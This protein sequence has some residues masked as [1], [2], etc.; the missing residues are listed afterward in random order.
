[1]KKFLYL[2]S[3]AVI[4][5][6]SC[7][8]DLGFKTQETPQVEGKYTI[9]ANYAEMANGE[10]GTRTSLNSAGQYQWDEG[11]A[12]G[13]FNAGGDGTTNA[14]FRYSGTGNAFKGDVDIFSNGGNVYAYYPFNA[15]ASITGT[16]SVLSGLYISQNQNFNYYPDF[17]MGCFAQGAAP[18]VAS[19]TVTEDGLTLSFEP[20]A[21]YLVVPVVGNISENIQNFELEITNS[22]STVNSGNNPVLWG[23]ITVNMSQFDNPFVGFQDANAPTGGD[24]TLK[25]NAGSKFYLDSEN[26]QYLWFVVPANTPL[27][28]MTFSLTANYQYADRQGNLHD[29]SSTVTRTLS[30][31]FTTERNK[32]YGVAS[33]ANGT[34]FFFTGDEDTFVIQTQQQFLEYAWI[35][36]NGVTMAQTYYDNAQSGIGNGQAMSAPYEIYSSFSS[37]INSSNELKPA[38]IA[39]DITFSQ[40]ALSQ[41]LK[42]VT[43]TTN[44]PAY[45]ASIYGQFLTQ[46]NIPTIGSNAGSVYSIDGNGNTLSN[47]TV[48]GNGMFA[49]VGSTDSY[50]GN[51]TLSNITVDESGL[52]TGAN[53]GTTANGK[54]NYAFGFTQTSYIIYDDVTVASNCKVTLPR[55]FSDANTMTWGVFDVLT[56]SDLGGGN[57]N[58]N[59]ETSNDLAVQL[60]VNSNFNFTQTT[61]YVT[62]DDFGS[63]I[64]KGEGFVLTVANNNTAASAATTVMNAINLN[65]YDGYSVVT[66]NATS[67]GV[68]NQGSINTSFWTGTTYTSQ[69]NNGGTMTAELLFNAVNTSGSQT[70]VLNA[71]LD[72]MNKNWY[73]TTTDALTVNFAANY[74]ISNVYID[75]TSGEVNSNG[76]VHW[77]YPDSNSSQANLT[78]FGEEAIVSN[79]VNNAYLTINNITIESSNVSTKWYGSTTNGTTTQF[80]A[81]RNYVAALAGKGTAQNVR[82]QNMVVNADD[83]Q[84]GVVGGLF[85]YLESTGSSYKPANNCT[86]SMD[87]T[88]GVNG[89]YLAGFLDVE[90][91]SEGTYT[92]T[93]GVTATGDAFGDWNFEVTPPSSTNA[94]SAVTLVLSGFSSSLLQN[95]M[96]VLPENGQYPNNLGYTVYVQ[97]SNNSRPSVQF[98][99]KLTRS[100]YLNPST[101]QQDYE[102]QYTLQN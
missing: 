84:Y 52:T 42:G 94:A 63:I 67:Q 92:I 75:G 31:S 51:V 25:L 53:V 60:Q 21:S 6:A 82:V 90:L 7:S 55:A 19:G 81:N 35:A 57:K 28:G 39:K 32:F 8:D 100:Q 50:V 68:A 76:Y 88:G 89:G 69:N 78:L 72:L 91:A 87:V 27:S 4:A 40:S 23:N 83:A 29:A 13:V 20:I 97:N 36:T 56:T 102:Y 77:M 58:V 54:I 37:M 5:L 65:G 47:L 79:T 73:A 24:N 9:Y 2:S 66:R 45:L 30:S 61:P 96:P 34:P 11:D 80:F 46:G 98:I 33:D 41:F 48:K 49:P 38:L 44:L 64:L 74:T 93:N 43:N 18:A 95:F 26:I 1:M 10:E 59:N 85:A 99:Y 71:N 17:S 86:V 12:I 14:M 15:Q 62:V 101:G 16:N 70:L 3:A 22:S